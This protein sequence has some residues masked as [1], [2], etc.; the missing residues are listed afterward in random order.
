MK[1]FTL[2]LLVQLCFIPFIMKAQTLTISV[3]M[4]MVKNADKV[5]LRGN[6]P[7]LSWEKT[8]LL[9]DED[10]DGIFSGAFNF[11]AAEQ[12]K[13]EF[14]FVYGDIEW[15]LNG[16]S[17][18][19]IQLD[20]L[21]KKTF[22][23]QF[24]VPDIPSKEDLAKV[25]F[26]AEDL[27]KDIEIMQKAYTSLHPGLYRYNTEEEMNQH[28]A[29]L[30]KE[31][32]QSMTLQETYLAFARFI[33]KIRCGHT[34]VNPYNQSDFVKGAFFFQPDKVPFTFDL[35]GKQMIVTYNL[36]EDK[37]LMP[38]YEITS[39]NGTAM[40]T[41]IETLLPYISAD[42]FQMNKRMYALQVKG[43]EEYEDFD[44]L[45]PLLFP[46]HDDQYQLEVYDH[47]AGRKFQTSVASIS[48]TERKKRLEKRYGLN[49]GSYEDSWQF[50][51]L[52]PDLAHL[53][54]GTFVT[55]KFQMD[56]KAF[57]KDAFEQ[58]KTKKIPNL[59]VDIRGN[60]GGM[61]AVIDE[62]A[63]YLLKEDIRIE[64]F[65]GLTRYQVAP[66]ELRPYINTWDKKFYDIS[67]WVEPHKN[68]FFKEKADQKPY[69]EIKK[70]NNKLTFQ[71]KTFLLTNAA[72]SSATF[73][74]ARMAKLGKIATLVGQ[75]T[76]ATQ[77]GI[78][79][80]AMFFLRLPNSGIEMDIPLFG[81]FP[82]NEKPDLG[83]E[84][85]VKVERTIDDILNGIDPEVEAV[86]SIISNDR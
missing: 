81:N 37:K 7:P 26:R 65:L 54:L 42:G 14:K 52:S 53:K 19:T 29:D 84:P 57:L 34:L 27:Q 67:S 20:E 30:K 71:G 36:S 80:G 28:F 66:E 44:I 50:K 63:K 68:G 49:T 76:G 64:E 48:T 43:I 39:I 69:R 40:E 11:K 38:G 31:M 32:S 6:L 17:N 82:Y 85:D 23:Y 35:I 59:I 18:R 15:E 12:K 73:Y 70:S 3:D 55:W 45:F 60:G 86:R 46:P 78:N 10:G 2:M 21:E 74:L 22:N 24:N 75:T 33:P 51:I 72:N 77:K 83:I 5:G 61:D 62:L 79:G 1:R 41:I 13:L 9:N 47:K 56:W 16:G 25:V 4:S 58:L 8:Y